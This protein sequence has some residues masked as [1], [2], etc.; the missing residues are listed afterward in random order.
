LTQLGCTAAQGYLFFAALPTE[1]IA[2]TLADL[3][4]NAGGRVIPFRNEGAS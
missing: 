3:T 2:G 4:R 1:R